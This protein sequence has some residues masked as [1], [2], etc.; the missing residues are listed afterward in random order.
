MRP[1]SLEIEVLN[2]LRE[3]PLSKSEI[4]KHLGHKHISGGLKKAFNQLL[5]QEEIIQTIPEK[6]DSRLQRYKL[7]N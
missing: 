4:S 2:L 7:H 5:K 3:G 1:E 6:P